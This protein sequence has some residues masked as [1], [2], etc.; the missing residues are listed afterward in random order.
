MQ[1]IDSLHIAIKGVVQGVGFR[2]FVYNLAQELSLKGFVTNTSDG[3]FI[4]VE[5]CNLD[6]F[7]ERVRTESPPLSKIMSVDISPSEPT[8]YTVFS[9]K[10]SSEKGTFTLVSPDISICNDCL[11]E[12]FDR[13]DRR[14]HYPFINCTNCGPRYT[15]TTSVPYD[16]R[17]TTMK[18]FE[19]CSDCDTEYH[20]PSNRRFHAQPNA[21]P[22][23]GPRVELTGID[24]CLKDFPIDS[25]IRS[26]RSL[27][28]DGK[29]IAVR[30]LG[31]FHLA[32]DAT[33]NDAVKKLRQ[34]KRKNNKP[35]AVMAPD[36]EA[37]T[38][39]CHVS[40]KERQVL[41]LPSR[42]IV[43][44][45]KRLPAVLTDAVAPQNSTLGCMLP[46]TP[47]HYLLFYPD[48]LNSA[49]DFKALVMTS[50]NL[51]EEPI[52]IDLDDACSRLAPVADAFLTH[53]RDIHMRVDDS[54]VQ[55]IN[56]RPDSSGSK[57]FFIRRSRG[58]APNPIP[59]HSD[60]PDVLGCGADIKNTFT[61]I[62]GRYAIPSQHIGDMEN[63]ETV[64]F[65]EETLHNL[66]A[67]YRAEP[68]AI[69][70]DLHPHYL[71]TKW[72]LQQKSDAGGRRITTQGIQHH[73]A[74]IAS[75]MAEKGF[76]EKVI[77]ISF[78]GNG[79]GADGTLWGGEFLICDI[80][81]FKRAAHLKYVPLPGSEMAVREPWRIAVSYLQAATG[82]QLWDYIRP[83]FIARHGKD[84]IEQIVTISEKREFSPLSSGAGRLFDAVSA[85]LGICDIN[86]YE[87][88][89]AIA[90][91]SHVVQ[92]VY[93][94]YPVDVT[95]QDM[96][97]IDFSYT[98]LKIIEDL[99]NNVPTEV[100]ATR[101]HNTVVT[102]IIAVTRKLSIMHN[103]HNVL[104]SGGVFQNR[105][106]LKRLLDAFA[107]EECSVFLNETV[108]CN[109][110]GI[111][112]GQA[113]L[114]RERIKRGSI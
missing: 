108:P 104:L 59:L 10:E 111:S 48:D 86:T 28:K 33:N 12:L 90:L 82:D 58:F 69:A 45:K 5:G 112:L 74:H 30:G 52:I 102:G 43:L 66:T 19:M 29:I 8:G 31:G 85:L 47:L 64:D 2:P 32:C 44:L 56:E 13:Q 41:S 101:F 107:Q 99:S 61:L 79:Y 25:P 98:I 34:R 75:V 54:V 114:L 22:Q 53:N 23:C 77:G 21:C 36:I 17:N 68:E 46:Y 71:S 6:D 80:H 92:D 11:R 16:R 89:A 83:E 62:K 65:F 63:Y 15:I 55:I 78:D 109:D 7:L 73:Y 24:I 87:G 110:A 91:E 94:D 113:Y 42:P 70:Y 9:I 105:Y 88:E 97:E 76:K 95:F 72:A 57:Y 27:L 49:P 40:E 106:L 51:S 39:I 20:D 18:V 37:I 50:G 60:G 84:R 1:A 81:G 96:I 35:F 93:E 67:A 26:A 14:Y 103:L 3:V 4:S 38:S 100:I